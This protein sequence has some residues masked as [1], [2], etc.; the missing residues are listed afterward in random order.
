MVDAHTYFVDSIVIVFVSKRELAQPSTLFKAFEMR[1]DLH[2]HSRFSTR[3]TLWIMQKVGCPE[4]LTEPRGLYDAA[5]LLGMNAVTITDH[6]MIEGALDIAHLPN[7]FVSCEYTSYFPEDRCKVHV[8]AYDISEAQHRELVEIR[9][10]I[11]E[12]AAY[13]NEHGI[14]HACAHP[15]F[16]PNDRLQA[17]HIEKLLLLFKVW[18]YNGDIAPE[19]NQAM[20]HLLDNLTEEDITQ[21][22]SR[23]ELEAYGNEPWRKCIITGSDDH[24]SLNL[25]SAFTEVRDVDNFRTFWDG[26]LKRQ[27]CIHVRPSTPEGLARSVYSIGYQ[28]YK[29]KFNLERYLKHDVFLLFMDR[30]LQTKRHDAYTRL[31]RFQRYLAQRRL[32]KQSVEKM[33]LLE[34]TRHEAARAF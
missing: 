2:C 32:S 19:M 26:V 10:N 16:G 24:S 23:Y 7:A 20:M 12:F 1:I 18:E 29:E 15:F 4:S 13:L 31:S 5:M 9:E 14:A 28:F 25:A 8:L 21:L 3:P 33:T 30:M 6:N 34:L 17:H 27:A 22:S 11:F